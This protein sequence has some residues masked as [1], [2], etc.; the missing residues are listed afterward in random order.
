ARR[1]GVHAR[2]PV[3]AA[4]PDRR[5]P[6]RRVRRVGA[7]AR[8]GRAAER[9]DG[10]RADRTRCR[11][12]AHRGLDRGADVTRLTLTLGGRETDVLV[13]TAIV[14]GWAGRDRA[15]VEHHIAELEALGVP[16]P[17]ST[18]VFYRVSASRLTTAA[19][20][21]STPASSGEVEPVLLH[22][23]GRVWVGVG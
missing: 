11:G 3:D 21:E 16:R 5:Q 18:P 13:H 1:R 4:Q 23:D 15:A 2:E 7:D 6:A 22:H 12:A 20:I 17:S 9:R 14:A 19:E 8:A 10:R